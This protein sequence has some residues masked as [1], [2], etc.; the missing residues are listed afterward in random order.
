M[1]DELI[2][3]WR[4]IK[5]SDACSDKLNIRSKRL[6]KSFFICLFLKLGCNIIKN[7]VLIS[8]VNKDI[9]NCYSLKEQMRLI[10]FESQ[11]YFFPN[12]MGTK[13]NVP[14]RLCEYSVS[15]SFSIKSISCVEPSPT[16]NTILPPI[17]SCDSS[18]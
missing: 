10:L 3:G 8:L 16:G 17:A 15:D 5:V 12:S 13:L 18:S 11:F 6:K 14:W 1:C 9:T 4:S 2:V 7:L